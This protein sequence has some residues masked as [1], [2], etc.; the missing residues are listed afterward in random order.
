[1]DTYDTEV[2]TPTA[3]Y[4]EEDHQTWS[5]LCTRQTQS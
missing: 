2:V 3:S 4:T 5:K 1:M